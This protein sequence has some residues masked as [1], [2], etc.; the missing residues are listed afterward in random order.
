MTARAGVLAGVLVLTAA[1]CSGSSSSTIEPPATTGATATAVATTVTTAPARP[2]AI[3]DLLGR[4]VVLAHAGGDDDYPHS[5][6]FA[7]GESVKAG[8]D[9]LDLDVRLSGDGVLIVHHD[10]DVDRTTNGT[11]PVASMTYA[12]LHALDNAYWFNTVCNTCKNRPESDYVWRGVRTGAKPPPAGSTPDDFAITT[13]RDLATRFPT[14]PLNIELKGQDTAA[15][16]ELAKELRELGRLDSTVVT[17]FDDD[18][19]TAFHALAPE[20]ALSPGL[21]TT[22]AWVLSGTPLP[23]GMR[24][25][26]IPPEYNGVTVLTPDLVA[27][28]KAA[29]YLLWVWPNG[30]AFENADGYARLFAM[31]VDGVNAS[32]PAA[33]VAAKLNG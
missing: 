1:A 27:R 13:F 11:G 30:G 10:D 9:V 24:I 15:A 2:P 5:T 18:L 25:L 7:F 31:G 28:A 22:T 12:Q 6:P 19:I 16:T 3:A 4:R 8:V 29:G 21:N 14:M 26:Q 33:G 23:D 32:K 20:V 17:S